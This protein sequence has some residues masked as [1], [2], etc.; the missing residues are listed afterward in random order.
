MLFHAKLYSLKPK[1]IVFSKCSRPRRDRGALSTSL[2]CSLP[3]IVSPAPT[4][5]NYDIDEFQHFPGVV[6]CPSGVFTEPSARLL[7]VRGRREEV[8]GHSSAYKR[9]SS[10][11]TNCWGRPF[12]DS[13][14][15]HVWTKVRHPGS[16]DALGNTATRLGHV[17]TDH[18]LAPRISSNIRMTFRRK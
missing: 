11:P 3:K 15:V 13:G 12:P 5:T 1:A 4:T 8:Q 16:Q 10:S 18:P 9:N 2:T 17:A 6:E 14:S 7:T